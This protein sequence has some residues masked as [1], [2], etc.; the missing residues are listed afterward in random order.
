[1]NVKDLD[2]GYLEIEFVFILI[3]FVFFYVKKF[4]IEYFLGLIGIDE[5]KVFIGSSDKFIKNILDLIED[6]DDVVVKVFYEIF[7]NFVILD[8]IC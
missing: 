7:I 3:V 8:F 4:V 6:F 5:G 2:L 1:M